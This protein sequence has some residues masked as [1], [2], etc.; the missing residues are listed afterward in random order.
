MEEEVTILKT[1]YQAL[2][3]SQSWL[4]ALEDAGVDNW[5]G[6]DFA[7]EIYDEREGE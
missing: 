6:Y 1:E 2:K 5:S 3:D 4:D 7:C